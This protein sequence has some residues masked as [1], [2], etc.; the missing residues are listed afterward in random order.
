MALQPDVLL[1]LTGQ[2]ATAVRLSEDP[3]FAAVPFEPFTPLRSFN[4]TSGDGLKTVF[5]EFQSAT[6]NT[7][8]ISAQINLDSVP[9]ALTVVQPISGEVLAR[10]IIV[11]AQ[12]MDA[13]GVDRVEF[14][15]DGILAAVDTTNDFSFDWDVRT[16][17]DGPHVLTVAAFD[18]LGRETRQD[19]EVNVALTP[20]PSPVITSPLNGVTLAATAVDVLG[21]AEPGIQLSLLVNGAFLQQ[22]LPDVNGDWSVAQV[23]LVE[24]ANS[25]FA[26]SVDS[27]GISAPSATVVVNADTGPPAAPA[28]L[29]A[30][31]LPDG[32]KLLDWI[33][34]DARDVTFYNLWRA[35]A[36]FVATSEATLVRGAITELT[37]SDTPPAEGTF[38][39]GVTA[40]DAAA[41]E[42]GLSPL[43][44]VSVDLTPP[45]ADLSFNPPGPVGPGTV[46][47]TLVVSEPTDGV[48]F[49]GITPQGGTPTTLELSGGPL[50]WNGSF[51]VV[52]DTPSG[53]AGASFSARDLA[54]VRGTGITG[55]ATLEIDTQGPQGS[56]AVAPPQPLYGPGT[57]TV[58]VV[59]DESAAATPTLRF[60]P[61]AGGTV[62]LPLTG[63]GTD[64]QADLTVDPVHG[65]G[66]A[67]FELD[68]Q[69]VLGNATSGPVAGAGIE[70]DVTP[71]GVPPNLIAGS[72]PAGDIDVGWDAV[73]GAVSYT[74]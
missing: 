19:I 52:L 72:R 50:S 9:P 74:L 33:P 14:S 39:Y 64:W 57:Y 7:A 30:E 24:G 34:S 2:T 4:F 26:T 40:V 48:P 13:A 68:A 35:V 15:V 56:L 59:L 44:Q 51:D 49:L 28:F 22:A 62:T 43:V 67:G 63:S 42:S 29:Q 58:D 32:V 41:N 54:G 53:T 25:I 16:L 17:P 60:L 10:P 12:A 8:V 11:M 47:V 69:D 23:P 61:S 37:A 36:P 31:D 18:S 1:K 21:T 66:P 38:H 20:P 71:P 5:A 6:G 3:L 65:D 73:S 45:T 46:D 27:V 70:L 55:G